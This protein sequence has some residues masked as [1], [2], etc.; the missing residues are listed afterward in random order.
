LT[1]IG[2]IGLGVMGEN[3]AKNISSKGFTITV[4]NRTLDRTRSF[5]ESVKGLYDIQAA[6]S[7]EDLVRSVEK[8]RRIIM[9]V[10]AGSA[11]DSVLSALTPHLDPG[12]M[13]FDC[14]NSHYSDTERRQRLCS[15]QGITFMG[16]GVSGGE[17]GALK[18]P[19]IMLGGPQQGYE[20]TRRFWEAIAARAEEEPCAGYMGLHGAGH[21][22]KMVHNGIEYGILQ[23]IAE[24]YDI[25][26]SMMGMNAFDVAEV[27]RRWSYGGLSSYL[28]EIASEALLVVDE[29]TGKPL[30]ELVLDRAEHKGTG[31]WAV[32]SAADLGVATPSIDA[33][34]SARYLS[35][36]KDQRIKFERIYGPPP[37]YRSEKTADRMLELL[38]DAYWCTAVAC[39]AQGLE[40]IRSASS[41]YGYG[42]NLETVLKVW[43]AGCI[44]R[45]RLIQDLIKAVEEAEENILLA[46]NIASE[47]RDRWSGFTDIVS[48]VAKTNIPTPVMDA[49]HNYLRSLRRAR[50]PANIIQAL[51]DRFGAHTFERTDRPGRFHHSWRP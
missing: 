12:D 46:S 14:G 3:L 1:A 51:R 13:I 2:L 9:M 48:E 44:I 25:L 10:Q 23:L 21:F 45:A 43:R 5:M 11:V 26:V 37:V 7:L 42:T 20:A 18:G 6:Y 30:V 34:L 31:K 4:Y 49:S 39:Y 28:L 50:L 27:F 17:E 38:E 29:E 32:Q 19:S 8:P 33:A 15:S 47:L 40:M 22:V 41:Q 35:T 16:V 24:T 36:I